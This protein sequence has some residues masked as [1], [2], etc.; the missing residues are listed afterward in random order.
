MVEGMEIG[1]PLIPLASLGGLSA[2]GTPP[3]AMGGTLFLLQPLIL[4]EPVRESDS[5]KKE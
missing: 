2:S 3:S 4:P 1:G 5:R